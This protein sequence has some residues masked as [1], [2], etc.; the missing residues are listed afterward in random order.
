MSGLRGRLHGALGVSGVSA[1]LH[2]AVR[3]LAEL[4]E[5]TR[6]ELDRQDRTMRELAV[7]LTERIASLEQRLA[8]LEART[9]DH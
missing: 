4:E 5:R 7:D 6:A 8:E 1:D 2:E 9:Q 3:R